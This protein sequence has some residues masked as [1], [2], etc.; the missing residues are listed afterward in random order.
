MVIAILLSHFVA[1]EH[2]SRPATYADSI[3]VLDEKQSTVLTLTATT[4]AA[5][6][7]ITLLPGD[8]ATPIAEKLADLSTG[9]LIVLCAIFLEKYLLTIIGY[10]S[11]AWLIP[12]A[13]ILL[14]IDAFVNWD[15]LKKLGSKLLIF[16]FLISLVIPSGVRISSLIDATYH[17][18]IE[19]TIEE[20]KSATAEIENET[21]DSADEKE[22]GFMSGFVSKVTGG[23][24]GLTSSIYEKISNAVNKTFEA[25]AVLLVT[26]CL[27]PI[28]VI[29]V[30]I[31]LINITFS[32]NLTISY[33]GM[34]GWA[35]KA[36]RK[37]GR[38]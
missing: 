17:S 27:I 13:L 16:G 18:S 25:L 36:L 14:S 38:E 4:T 21:A 2:L 37:K 5:S 15:T 19:T 20:T 8:V 28:L 10:V 26:S 34:A 11:F 29:F 22:D 35:R 6:A 23:I 33:H 3:S 32:S 31:W 30:F 7:A 12:F 9:F 24:S 1:A